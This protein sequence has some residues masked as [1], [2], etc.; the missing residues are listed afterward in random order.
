[1]S[2]DGLTES[3]I[4]VRE[5]VSEICK[6]FPDEYW[7]E[8][9]R[10]QTYPHDLHREL[11]KGGWIGICMPEK[12]GGSGLGISEATVMLQTIS[13]S[14][15][16]IMGAQTIHANVYAIWAFASEEQRDRW[17]EPIISGKE[18]A[19]FGVTEPNS[20]LNTL[21]LQTKAE[22]KGDKYV[23][24][25]SKI[26]I[27]SAQV[28]QQMVLLARTTQ[29]TSQTK[30][31]K[32]L[33][34]F[35]A[36]IKEDDGI[37]L[38]KGIELRK[39]EKMGGRGVDANQVF[40]DNFEIPIQDRIGEEGEGFKQ[41]LH[42]MNA[43]RCLL[44]GEALGLGYAALRRATRYASERV[45][46]DRPIGQN[47]AIQHPLAKSWIDLEAGKLLTYSAARAYD[48]YVFKSN[49]KVNDS[50]TEDGKY[51]DLGAR[52][53]AAKYFAAEAAFK[54]WTHG[55]MGYSSDYHVERYLREIFVP[56]IAPVSREM[57]LN[58]VS[59]RILGLP[60]SY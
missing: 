22:R 36:R 25:G 6:Q 50:S 60:R 41:I 27:S 7:A 48:D 51:T 13:E 34:L 1:M 14:G 17:L 57:I 19:C 44:A 52:C 26:W 23:V 24:N 49:L 3:Q 33:S 42:G 29:L 43:E 20:G 16:G 35:F 58:Y 30:P 10:T 9:D 54:T 15:A 45:V 5:A 53:N 18:R 28:A 59:Q 39:I 47:Q 4:Q 56:R 55:G 32:A 2:L 8:K 38:K 12:Y 31:S 46:F 11:A 40:F 37:T 21:K